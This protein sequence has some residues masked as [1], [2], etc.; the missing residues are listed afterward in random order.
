MHTFVSLN[1]EIVQTS[2][3]NLPIFSNSALYGKGVFTTIAISNSKPFLWQSHWNRL[4]A[5]AKSLEIELTQNSEQLILESLTNLI[6]KNSIS[7]ARARLTIFDTSPAS[8]WSSASESKTSVLIQTGD[9]KELPVDMELTISQFP[10]NSR[11]VL[12]GVKSCNYLENILAYE[13][14]K[15]NGFDEAVRLNE[16]GSI[17]SACLA[18]VFWIKSGTLHTP[19]LAT[20]CLPGT[21][22]RLVIEL[23][24]DFGYEVKETTADLPELL[25]VDEIFLTST[26][27][28]VS[29][30][31]KIGDKCFESEI[32]QSFRA[33]IAEL[34]C[35]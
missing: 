20:G 28:S 11:S 29:G 27:L 1:N 26:G 35:E 18:N 10:I 9:L 4:S 21:T 15:A 13:D 34:K 16:K 23:S 2:E 31:R 22:R 32:T 3:I 5:N 7:E 14:A 25:T 19:A 30:V 33:K 17:T 8:V 24:R 12:C 6:L